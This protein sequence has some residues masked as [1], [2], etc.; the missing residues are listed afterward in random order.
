MI[1]L[2]VPSKF[3]PEY[4]SDYPSYTSGKNMEEICYEYF[5]L[6]KD[7]INTEYI[8]LPVFWTSYYVTNISSACI[9]NPS[10]I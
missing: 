9:L 1:I 5:L 4:K 7:N 8:Y 10:T 6:N 3:K 2:D